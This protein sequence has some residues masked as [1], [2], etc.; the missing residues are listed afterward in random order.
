MER[1]DDFQVMH[2]ITE[3]KGL[4]LFTGMINAITGAGMYLEC[5]GLQGENLCREFGPG[6]AAE[7]CRFL[8]AEPTDESELDDVYWLAYEQCNTMFPAID[9]FVKVAMIHVAGWVFLRYSTSMGGKLF[10][11]NRLKNC[12][13]EVVRMYDEDEAKKVAKY[14]QSMHVAAGSDREPTP[15]PSE[16][17]KDEK[18]VKWK[19]FQKV[20][21]AT[22]KIEY[23]NAKV[24]KF[25]PTTG[26]HT[27]QYHV[28]YRPETKRSWLGLGL[29]EKRTQCTHRRHRPCHLC[30]YDTKKVVEMNLG[31]AR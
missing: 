10:L 23:V 15:P 7:P 31:R 3:F 25:N 1:R 30:K 19:S 4:Q 11:D 21:S 28:P 18:K 14:R 13:I 6:V 22:K 5:A 17:H 20:A 16:V 29:F 24:V 9:F 12:I 27:L 2:F 26:L 8:F